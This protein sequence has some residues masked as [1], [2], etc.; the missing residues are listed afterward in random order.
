MKDGERG[1]GK[2]L[3]CGEPFPA[4]TTCVPLYA[5][6]QATIRELVEA[7][8]H[9]KVCGDCAENGLE[10]CD[11]GRAVLEVLKKATKEGRG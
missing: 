6:S 1:A 11:G 9:L 8:K 4:G 3:T 5:S 2:C 10:N 7:V